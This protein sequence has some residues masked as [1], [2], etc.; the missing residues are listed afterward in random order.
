MKRT[1]STRRCC[2]ITTLE[3]DRP[4]GD[5]Q[6]RDTNLSSRAANVVTGV[7]NRRRRAV[8]PTRDSEACTGTRNQRHAS[9]PQFAMFASDSGDFLAAVCLLEIMDSPR[10][11]LNR[12]AGLHN[13]RSEFNSF[14]VLRLCSARTISF[15]LPSASPRSKFSFMSNVCI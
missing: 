1:F 6:P 8:L 15:M 11:V 12:R 10:D 9:S 7:R 3:P 14:L 5:K 13:F 2:R 4:D